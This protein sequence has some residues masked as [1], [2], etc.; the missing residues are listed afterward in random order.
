MRCHS[1]VFILLEDTADHR[2]A[3]LAEAKVTALNRVQQIKAEGDKISI[4]MADPNWELYGRYIEA[5]KAKHEM[6]AKI[7][8]RKL[9]DDLNPLEPQEERRARLGLAHNRASIEAF[10]VALSIA[11]LLIER[12]Q[13][14]QAEIAKIGSDAVSK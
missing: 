8:E 10:N 7:I 4:L 2:R 1:E 3:K 12:G 9:L 6:S 11:K 14:A 13:E 5:E